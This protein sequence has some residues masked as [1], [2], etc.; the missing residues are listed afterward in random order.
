[1][2]RKNLQRLDGSKRCREVPGEGGKCKWMIM[3]IVMK[4][5]LA[6]NLLCINSFEALKNE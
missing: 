2:A 5:L 3:R 4:P 1:V 6:P